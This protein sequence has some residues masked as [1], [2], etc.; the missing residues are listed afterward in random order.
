MLLEEE[1]SNFSL[2]LLF[3]VSSFVDGFSW[4]H[5]WWT[6]ERHYESDDQSCESGPVFAAD[7]CR[8]VCQCDWE[9]L[10]LLH[11][12]FRFLS[13]LVLILLLL[14]ILRNCRQTTL[15]DRNSKTWL[16]LSRSFDNFP[17]QK[18]GSLSRLFLHV[19]LFPQETHMKRNWK[20]GIFLPFV[21]SRK[22]KTK[23]VTQS[24]ESL[25]FNFQ[26]LC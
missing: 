15:T 13:M 17:L 10:A 18:E 3:S 4:V 12:R 5:L 14:L 7:V 24:K 21:S 19:F 2:M 25:V 26:S 22:E 11:F 9:S 8:K 23:S 6:K 20:R 16:L 1:V